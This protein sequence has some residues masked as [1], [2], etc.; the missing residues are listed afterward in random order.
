MSYNSPLIQAIEIAI[1][2]AK[3]SPCQKSKRGVAAYFDET[4]IVGAFNG[5][6]I[7]FGCP[8]I[9]VCGQKCRELA[10]HAESRALRSIL[11]WAARE[12][13]EPSSDLM[14]VHVK[15][16]N[17]N[18]VPSGNPSCLPCAAEIVEAKAFLWLFHEN[19]WKCYNGVDLYQESLKYH[20]MGVYGQKLNL[21]GMTFE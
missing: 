17:G 12:Q 16:E 8:G 15:V 11:T 21:L 13:L 2:C 1:Q 4:F 14:L 3:R 19:G 10:R 9:S 7:P 20:G 5:P 18:L 6:P